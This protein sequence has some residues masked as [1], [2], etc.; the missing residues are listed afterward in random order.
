MELFIGVN[1]ER[2]QELTRKLSS[3]QK[4]QG[5][6]CCW[7]ESS[8]EFVINMW[9]SVWNQQQ[10]WRS[11][12]SFVVVKSE[13]LLWFC[14]MLW[15]FTRNK[16]LW[17]WIEKS[18]SNKELRVNLVT[19]NF[20][21]G[22]SKE[23]PVSYGKAKGME[24]L[25]WTQTES[26]PWNKWMGKQTCGKCFHKKC[27]LELDE[28]TFFTR[29][30][31]R[32]CWG[33]TETHWFL[34]ELWDFLWFIANTMKLN[35]SPCYSTLTMCRVCCLSHQCV[36]DLVFSTRIMEFITRSSLSTLMFILW[37]S[38]FLVFQAEISWWKVISHHIE[39]SE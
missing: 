13:F 14:C 17:L 37:N 34:V 19:K 7:Q 26:S 9:N 12:R 32:D 30:T 38:D 39:E 20:L 31:C 4:W 18:L 6:T 35:N 1:D 28:W 10:I 5:K 25:L 11:T 22:W 16:L 23:F 27:V 36:K 2:E 3:R 24:K 33:R 8:C 15:N 29:N 21:W